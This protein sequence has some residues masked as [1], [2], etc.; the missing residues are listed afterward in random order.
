MMMFLP[1]T[2]TLVRE[3]AMLMQMSQLG[4]KFILFKCDVIYDRD[5]N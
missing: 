3:V 4:N 2:K 5:I 1:S